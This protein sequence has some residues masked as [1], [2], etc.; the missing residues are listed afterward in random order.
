M[1]PSEVSINIRDALPTMNMTIHVKGVRAM[2]WRL[3]LAGILL[4]IAC[5]ILLNRAT[6]EI[7]D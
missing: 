2:R 6:L 5:W 1:K 7:K 3:Y 4:R